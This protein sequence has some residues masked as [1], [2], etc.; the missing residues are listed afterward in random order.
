[1]I[2]LLKNIQKEMGKSKSPTIT[3]KK[4]KAEEVVGNGK[5]N[6]KQKKEEP[7]KLGI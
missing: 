2:H 7:K 5:V 3:V 1:M 6:K 4:E